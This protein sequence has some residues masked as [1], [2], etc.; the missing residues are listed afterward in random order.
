MSE[1]I[2]INEFSIMF[3]ISV[4]TCKCRLQKNKFL[5]QPK[6]HRKEVI[7]LNQKDTLINVIYHYTLW[8]FDKCEEVINEGMI[9]V[10]RP[11]S[12]SCKK[13]DHVEDYPEAFLNLPIN[14]F[15]TAFDNII[16][17]RKLN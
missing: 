13:Y 2:T 3:G 15:K 11:F 10:V 8:D 6:H 12:K 9:Q 7:K 4:A 1:L 5:I 17:L 16:T 14:S